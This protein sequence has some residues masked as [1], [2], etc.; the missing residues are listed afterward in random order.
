MR[1]RRILS[2][3]CVP[4]L[5]GPVSP[6]SMQGFAI[7]K[8]LLLVHD[9]DPSGSSLDFCL[10]D[11]TRSSAVY[12]RHGMRKLWRRA[13]GR[14]CN[15]NTGSPIPYASPSLTVDFPSTPADQVRFWVSLTEVTFSNQ[16]V[17]VDQPGSIKYHI[18]INL[19]IN[20]VS[21]VTWGMVTQIAKSTTQCAK[22]VC[23]QRRP[24]CSLFSNPFT[25]VCVWGGCALV[26]SGV[27]VCTCACICVE[28]SEISVQCLPQLLSTSDFEIGALDESG[29]HSFIKTRQLAN[30][31]IPPTPCLPP[32]PHGWDYRASPRRLTHFYLSPGN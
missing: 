8:H 25:C 31:G 3:G 24:F 20:K 27:A 19:N 21:Q 29:T 1:S 23:V 22:M 9:V 16:S 15:F 12:F 18:F 13:G 2:W 14:E 6:K 5:Q 28:K 17:A 7:S 11:G 10:E 30:P 26:S 32:F 4:P